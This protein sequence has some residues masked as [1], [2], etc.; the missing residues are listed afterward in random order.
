MYIDKKKDI[1]ICNECWSIFFLKTIA[2]KKS[3]LKRDGYH[4][5]SYIMIK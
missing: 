3:D 4:S 2:S 1:K 5:L